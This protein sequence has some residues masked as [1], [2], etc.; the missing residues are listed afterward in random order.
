MSAFCSAPLALL[1]RGGR[2]GVGGNEHREHRDRHADG[3][4]RGRFQGQSFNRNPT[5]LSSAAAMRM[6]V[7]H[8]VERAIAQARF[9]SANCP[10]QPPKRSTLRAEGSISE[11]KYA[12]RTF[13]PAMEKGFAMKPTE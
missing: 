5:R 7:A 3:R 6:T 2:R 9:G 13:W 8:T 10:Y 1:A 12:R 4:W 11:S